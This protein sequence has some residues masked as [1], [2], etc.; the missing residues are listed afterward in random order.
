MRLDN[1]FLLLILEDIGCSLPLKNI[2][3]NRCPFWSEGQILVR[4]T[5]G[6]LAAHQKKASSCLFT[7]TTMNMVEC[8]YRLMTQGRGCCSFQSQNYS[9]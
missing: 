9:R 8:H 1:N 3:L 6:M 2:Q 4:F 5:G 7:M